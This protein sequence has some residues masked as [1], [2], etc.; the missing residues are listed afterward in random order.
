MAWGTRAVVLAAGLLVVLA[1]SAL[2]PYLG[3][4]DSGRV[5]TSATGTTSTALGPNRYASI[6]ALAPKYTPQNDTHPP[7]LHSGEWLQP[8]S[9]PGPINTA[10]AEDSPFVT[11]DGQSFF[12]FFTPDLRLPVTQQLG[13][14]VT[15]IWWSSRTEN[16]WSDPVRIQLGSNE[17]L[18]GCEFVLGD[19]MW[20]CSAR[21]GNYRGVDIYTAR[22]A[23]GGWTDVRNAGRLINQVF[24]VGEMTIT[25]DNA[26]MYYGSNGEVWALDKVSGNWTNP[27]PVPGIQITSGENQ[28]FVTPDGRQ[29]WFTGDS[30]L[31]YPGPALFRAVW[32]GTGW[33][34][35]VEV[36]SQFAGEPALD[37]A[38]NLYF[39]HHYLDGNGSLAEADIYVAYR[40]TQQGALAG[41]GVLAGGLAALPAGARFEGTAPCCDLPEA[42]IEI[43]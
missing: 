31:G 28:P 39:V 6:P 37:A 23:D 5:A 29:L 9:M 25:P 26:T 41:P 3:G 38:G 7:V 1:V 4:N 15:G 43:W 17:S 8:V 12:F 42:P 35:P 27:H 11:A 18:D 33:S 22:C 36:V 40:S 10:G 2:I 32:N 20:F 16:G 14:G 24:Q 13:D 21:A 30:K 19:T 34:T